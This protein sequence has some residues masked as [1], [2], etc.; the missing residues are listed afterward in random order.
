MGFRFIKGAASLDCDIENNF[1]RKR[2]QRCTKLRKSS[3]L[4]KKKKLS[5]LI[6]AA[7]E[8]R[9]RREVGRMGGVAPR[10]PARRGDAITLWNFVNEILSTGGEYS[11]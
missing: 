5:L 9:V 3:K 10:Y 6:R 8:Q 7:A 11:F 4:Q 2:S 1:D